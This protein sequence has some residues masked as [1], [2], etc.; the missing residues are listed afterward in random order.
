MAAQASWALD[1]RRRFHWRDWGG[2]SVVYEDWSGL[3][4]QFAPLDAAVMACFEESAAARSLE[5][6]ERLLGEG[7]PAAERAE[8]R[9]ALSAAVDRFCKL[10]WLQP[11]PVQATAPQ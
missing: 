10:G 9:T 11:R 1:P 3:T 4:W 2:D 8:L 5:D 7:W 6:L